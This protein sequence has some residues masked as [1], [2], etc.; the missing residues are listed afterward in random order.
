MQ[1]VC[2]TT[3][4]LV[5]HAGPAA[6]HAEGWGLWIV[7]KCRHTIC[8]AAKLGRLRQHDLGHTAVSHAV[9]S[10]ENL[11]LVGLLKNPPS[12]RGECRTMRQRPLGGWFGCWGRGT[13]LEGAVPA[14]GGPKMAHRTARRA[15]A[16]RLRLIAGQ[17]GL[18]FHVVETAPDSAP[19]PVPGLGL[20]VEALGTPK[21]TL[22]QPLIVL[23]PPCTPTPSPEQRRVVMR[24]D[25]LLVDA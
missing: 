2:Q 16:S 25:H 14:S 3:N 21:V 22:V 1:N 13:G 5:R 10:G 18:D 7:T 11:P 24:D 9:M 8:A 20:A 17:V 12:D 4:W 6:L 15:A 23:A 19:E